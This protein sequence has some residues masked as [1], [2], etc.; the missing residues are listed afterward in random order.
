MSDENTYT[1]GADFTYTPS[2]NSLPVGFLAFT[3]RAGSTR[4]FVK[5]GH[6]ESWMNAL[7]QYALTQIT[8]SI[9]SE[10]NNWLIG[11]T[12]TGILARGVNGNTPY[13]DPDTFH[14]WIGDEDTGIIA[15]GLDGETPTVAIDTNTKHWIIN[16]VDT[17][18]RCR[19]KRR[20]TPRVFTID[21]TSKHWL[22]DGVDTGVKAEGQDGITP[23]IAIDSASKHWLINGVDTGVV[24]EGKDGL[25]AYQIWLAQGNEGTEPRLSRQPARPYHDR[26]GRHFVVCWPT[27][28]TTTTT[29]R[30]PTSSR[31]QATSWASGPTLDDAATSPTATTQKS[32]RRRRG[33]IDRVAVCCRAR[34][35]RGAP[36]ARRCSTSTP[37]RP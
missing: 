12:D 24:A 7:F 21:G 2:T 1:M 27:P 17:G 37:P 18:R 30:P 34:L 26:R 13:V 11:G 3:L 20:A 35:F 28:A 32:P 14:W 36:A 8:P 15:R 29:R 6:P 16:D 9:D 5:V 23:V 19:G 4:A 25:S 22:V 10:S 31:C 33:R